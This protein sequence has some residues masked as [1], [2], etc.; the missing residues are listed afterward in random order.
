MYVQAFELKFS[1]IYNSIK[2]VYLT[3]FINHYQ[4]SAVLNK[5]TKVIKT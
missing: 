4:F 3:W 2:N 1:K 5:D